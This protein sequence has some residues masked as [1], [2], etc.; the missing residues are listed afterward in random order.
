MYR[1]IFHLVTV[2]WPPAFCRRSSRG[3]E[4]NERSKSHSQGLM[5]SWEDKTQGDEGKTLIKEGSKRKTQ[6]EAMVHA[7]PD[8]QECGRN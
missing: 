3:R 6:L 5:V 7:E 1:F 2:S 4:G 8:S